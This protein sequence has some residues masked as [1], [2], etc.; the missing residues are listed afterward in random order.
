MNGILANNIRHY[1]RAM[2]ITQQSL[3]DRLYVSPQTVS[4]WESG[5]SEPDTDKLCALSDAFGISLDNLVRVPN[6][7]ARKAYI[8]ID[9]GGT[10]TDFVLFLENGDIIERLILDGCNPNAYGLSH[11]KKI[12]AEGID[13]LVRMGA[14]VSALFAGISGASAGENR[15]QLNEYLTERYPYLESR[16][17]GDIHNIIGSAA[18]IEKC[19]A[20]ICGTGSVV[21]AYDGA[22]LHRYGGWGYL[23]DSAGSGFDIGRELFRY[24]LECED[25]GNAD[26]ELYLALREKL[27][28][29]IFE[30][31]SSIYSKGK[32]YIAS[33][34]PVVFKMCDSGNPVAI[35]IVTSSAQRLSD[36]INRAY[37]SRDC[38][39]TA[40]IAG[41]LISRKDILEPML[42]ERVNAD[43]D[44]VF[45]EQPPVY[46][47]AVKCMRLFGGAFD[48]DSFAGIFV[49]NLKQ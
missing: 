37:E 32:D 20:V 41:G 42:R 35:G 49:K 6:Y 46:G 33:F 30:N 3:A 25:M 7:T 5:L 19:I 18:E 28:G 44:L 15:K 24:C 26:D 38:G 1:R 29:A 12:L 8:A 43:I 27:G 17:E 39:N 31:I 45:A 23:F 14:R 34:A 36:L 9:G 21:Y 11:T 48:K 16:V 2:G 13:R 40:I 4:K 10:K 22:E 47:A